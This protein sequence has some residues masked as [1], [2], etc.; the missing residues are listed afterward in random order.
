MANQ[1]RRPRVRYQT[2]PARGRA[3]SRQRRKVDWKKLALWAA[4]GVV[5]VA[6]LVLVV[7]GTGHQS[8]LDA[9]V[10]VLAQQEA[11]SGTVSVHTGPNHTV[12]QWSEPLPTANAPRADGKPTLV[13]FSATT[14]TFCEHMQSYAYQT[15][16]PF[17]STMAFVEK[18]YDTGGS[19]DFGRYGVAG[20]PTFILIDAKGREIARFGFQDSAQRFAAA[21]QAALA[22]IPR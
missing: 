16:Q 4:A 15:A 13:W 6:A 22:R 1:G 11:G 9:A 20:T 21:I 7:K 18:G 19:G 14:C 3:Q 17:T 12:Y 10:A 2:S 5:A 8:K